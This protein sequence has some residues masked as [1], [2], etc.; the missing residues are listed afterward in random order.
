MAEAWLRIN[1]Y[2]YMLL[3]RVEVMGGKTK[4]SIHKE[5]DL[6]QIPLQG[7]WQHGLGYSCHLILRGKCN[8]NG[9]TL[10]GRQNH[11]STPNPVHDKQSREEVGAGHIPG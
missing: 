11:V 4:C 1:S 8:Q 7:I 9:S 6:L 2:A 10:K 5:G 3:P